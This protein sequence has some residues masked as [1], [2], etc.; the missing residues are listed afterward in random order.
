MSDD[1]KN[2]CDCGCD[3]CDDCDE[4]EIYTLSDENGEESQFCLIGTLEHDGNTYVALTPMDDDKDEYVI[5]RC[6]ITDGE[7][8]FYTIDDDDEFDAV[9]DQ[10]EDVFMTEYDCDKN[11]FSVD[12]EETEEEEN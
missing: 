1:I 2:G 3:D 6:A 5:L 12:D 7:E 10:F 9:A 8:T 4:M 11:G